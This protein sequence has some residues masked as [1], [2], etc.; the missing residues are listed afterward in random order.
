[1]RAEK[2]FPILVSGAGLRARPA[3]QLLGALICHWNYLKYCAS[4]LMF[5]YAKKF[6]RKL[7]AIW[8]FAHKMFSSYVLGLKIN[9]KLYFWKSVQIR[10]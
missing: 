6:L 1:M 9:T 10:R 2:H 4:K 3:R 5:P 8:T 7:F